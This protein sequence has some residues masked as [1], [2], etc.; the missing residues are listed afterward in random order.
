MNTKVTQTLAKLYLD[1]GYCRQAR[2]AFA[3][4]KMQAPDDEALDQGY[5]KAQAQVM[6]AKRGALKRVLDEWCDLAG[7]VTMTKG[8]SA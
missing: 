6:E 4:L 1:Q 2:D 3:D 7:Q 5:Q 8:A